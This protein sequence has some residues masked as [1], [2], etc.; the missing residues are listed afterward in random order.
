MRKEEIAKI[1]PQRFQ[2]TRP[3]AQESARVL[4]GRPAG[5]GRRSDFETLTALV[6]KHYNEVIGT[7]PREDRPQ[8]VKR[9]TDEACLAFHHARFQAAGRQIF[10]FEGD[11][12]EAF[13]HTDVD[14]VPVGA[15]KPPFPV[16]YL[17]FG[18]QADLDLYGDGNVVDGAYL[19]HLPNTMIEGEPKTH[20]E[21]WLTTSSSH[22]PSR[23]WL[24]DD[25]T[26]HYYLG[27]TSN[28]E[29]N[30][31]D[32]LRKAFQ[33]D[34][35]DR[36]AHAKNAP[37]SYST[38]MGE[39]GNRSGQTAAEAAE[40]LATGFPVFMEVLRLVVNGLAYVT[41]Y[42]EDAI[43]DWGDGAPEGVV[44]KAQSAAK[45]KVQR[46]ARNELRLGGF[47][48]VYL[49][50]M[51]KAEPRLSPGNGGAHDARRNLRSHWRRGHWRNQPYGVGLSEHRLV[52]IKP[53]FVKGSESSEAEEASHIYVVGS[54][55]IPSYQGNRPR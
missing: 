12:L 8:S 29:A 38:T 36:R 16:M 13:R 1:H 20:L 55:A 7:I 23:C 53:V 43:P 33:N 37:T 39:L 54:G 31:A 27:L 6:Q 28:E 45:P 51:P 48:L 2:A 9:L 30:L 46:N 22:V 35:E 41:S 11:L 24:L 47:A 44:S 34:L 25:L 26:N 49:C 40:L 5:F 4:A 19:V 15:I 3:F 21:V 32:A 17:H 10:H 42:F 18:P 14:E 50:R 52:W